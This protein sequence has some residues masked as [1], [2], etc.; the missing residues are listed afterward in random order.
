MKNGRNLFNGS[1]SID[2]ISNLQLLTAAL[3]TTGAC[4]PVPCLQPVLEAVSAVLDLVERV[5][6]N[7][8]DLKYLAESVIDITTLLTAELKSRPDN[9]D[10]RLV[11]LCTDF[12]RY[13]DDVTK[14]LE[15][16][17]SRKPKFWFKKYLKAKSIRDN[18][19]GFIRRLTDLRADLTVG[20]ITH[21]KLH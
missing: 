3:K 10:V 8:T 5:G 2:W 7:E 20:D 18:V 17:L 6:K 12:V 19:D 15:K 13:L 9:A 16:T 14:E 4:V 21:S 11:D 1:T